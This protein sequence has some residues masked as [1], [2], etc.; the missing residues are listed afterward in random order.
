MFK[1]GSGASAHRV[2]D[3]LKISKVRPMTEE[4]ALVAAGAPV[5][6]VIGQDNASSPE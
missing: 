5:A 3:A 4:I 1:P 2:A 6:V